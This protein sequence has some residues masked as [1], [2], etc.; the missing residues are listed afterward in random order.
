MSD[1][2][3]VIGN[4]GSGKS[5][6]LRNL[7]PLETF[8]I[9]VTNKQLPIQG[10]KRKYTPFVVNTGEGNIIACS[11]AADIVKILKYINIK[12]PEIKQII[13]DDSGYVMSFE[14][15]DKVKEKG[16]EKFTELAQN[17]YMI[18]KTAAS[19]R[20]DLK[21]FLFGHEENV[22]DAVN[23][24]RKFKTAGK[25]IDTQIV[26]EGLCT[27][28]FFAELITGENGKIEYKFATQTDGTTTAKTPMGCFDEMYIDNDLQ[29]VITA[30]DKYNEG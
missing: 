29:Y 4:T 22:G 12:K 14:S 9:N 8:V 2:A 30:I 25:L 20:D 10:A 16:Y 13:V 24:K 11:S 26:V 17:F 5:S 28:V 15:M 18:L 7:N 21:V 19:L 23:P 3:L 6:S 1:L 27:Y